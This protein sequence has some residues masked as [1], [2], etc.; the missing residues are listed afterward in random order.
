MHQPMHRIQSEVGQHVVENEP[1]NQREIEKAAE[2]NVAGR[3]DGSAEIQRDGQ[4]QQAVNRQGG[5]IAF[6]DSAVAQR[7]GG[8]EQLSGGEEQAEETK[9]DRRLQIAAHERA[10]RRKN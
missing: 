9:E 7:A 10:G 6:E 3:D 4:E 1:H 8:T 5:E 2:Y